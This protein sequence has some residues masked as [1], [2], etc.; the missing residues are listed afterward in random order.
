MKQIT[1][2]VTLYDGNYQENVEIEITEDEIKDL[3]ARKAFDSHSC[4]SCET[5]ELTVTVSA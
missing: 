4:V 2:I 3:A 5:K 1:A